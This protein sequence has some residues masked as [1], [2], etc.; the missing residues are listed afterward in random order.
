MSKFFIDRPVFAWVIALVIMLV[1]VVTI[2]T[3]P[4]GQLRSLADFLSALKDKYRRSV[5]H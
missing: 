2:M 3:L 1:G 5:L 4:I